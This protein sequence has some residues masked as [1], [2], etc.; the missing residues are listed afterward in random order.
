[1]KQC[2]L[3]EKASSVL[4]QSAQRLLKQILIFCK[5]GQLTVVVLDLLFT[6]IFKEGFFNCMISKYCSIPE[7][8]QIGPAVSAWNSY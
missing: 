1:M 7:P 5:I 6:D 3:V 8:T 2:G 4:L